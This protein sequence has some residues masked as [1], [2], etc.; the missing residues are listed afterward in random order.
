LFKGHIGQEYARSN[1]SLVKEHNMAEQAFEEKIYAQLQN[2]K[3]QLEK[4]EATAKGKI[5]QAEID[6]MNYLKTKRQEIDKKR[7]EM[8]T[9]AAAKADQIKAEIESEMPKFKESLDRLHAKVKSHLA[10]K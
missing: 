10:A 1:P 5:A 4:L 2:A 8:K 7:Q 9:A 6:A 3:A